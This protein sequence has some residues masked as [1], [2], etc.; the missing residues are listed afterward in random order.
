MKAALA[1]KFKDKRLLIIL[2]EII[3]ST[4]KGVPIGNYT[5][6]YFANFFLT[7]MDHWIKEILRVKPE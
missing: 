3:D 5:S 7:P 6:Q 4:D 1:R 2:E